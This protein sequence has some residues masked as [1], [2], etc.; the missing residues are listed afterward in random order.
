MSIAQMTSIARIILAIL[1]V[2]I[3]LGGLLIFYFVKIKKKNKAVKYEVDYD[4]YDRK[5]AVDLCKFEDIVD[6][7]IITDNGRRFVGVI[8]VRG[9]DYFYARSDE[10]NRTEIGYSTFINMIKE[11]MVYRQYTK[12]VDLSDT[13]EKYQMA[14]DNVESN[15]FICSEEFN[16][17]REQYYDLKE[18]G[19]LS[20]EIEEQILDNLEEKA[21]IMRVLEYRRLH[22]S[23]NLE[24]I[25]QVSKHTS[26]EKIQT[27]LFDWIY[28][29]LVGV[30]DMSEEQI[31]EKAVTELN[32]KAESFIHALGNA[33][34]R[35]SRVGT[36]ELIHMMRRH[37]H[38]LTADSFTQYAHNE[39]NFFDDITSS[40]GMR[41]SD[42]DLAEETGTMDEV[43]N[44]QQS[45]YEEMINR[46]V[47][48]EIAEEML[49]T[50]TKEDLQKERERVT[51]I[52]TSDDIKDRKEA[53]LTN[54]FELH[55][56]AR[57]EEEERN[58]KLQ[59]VQELENLGKSGKSAS[60]DNI[61]SFLP[62]IGG[63]N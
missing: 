12:A 61:S 48:P 16:E 26:P 54:R 9:F 34:V 19:E 23:D 31:R 43:V 49:G 51:Q 37:W 45:K 27:Y 62:K 1:V 57:K 3:V 44:L 30:G 58:K 41:E 46:G 7:M 8:K 18:K 6:N 47:E 11:P 24:Y 50:F 17:M 32:R 10:R 42:Y 2:L 63:G 21:E 60:A 13:R 56:K 53:I 20:L 38:P 28:D 4:S 40:N 39:S 5:D 29:P 14:Y 59:R 25:D 52:I 36:D 33:G 55:E 35:A 15:L 22:L